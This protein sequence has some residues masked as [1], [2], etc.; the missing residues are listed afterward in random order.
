[1]PSPQL[2]LSWGTGAAQTQ[3]A[4]GRCLQSSLLMLLMGS[5]PSPTAMKEFPEA[6]LGAAVLKGE[7]L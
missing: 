7:R 3:A 5:C 6:L 4:A 1:M 2:R